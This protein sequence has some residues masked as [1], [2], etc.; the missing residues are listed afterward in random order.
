LGKKLSD[1]LS[2]DDVDGR[3][4]RVEE[5]L[6]DPKNFQYT[7][8]LQRVDSSID[9]V[10]DFLFNTRRGHCEYFASAAALLLRSMG[11]PTRVVNG[12]KG[13]EWNDLAGVYQIRQRM[14]HSWVEAYVN[15]YWRTVDPS[16]V[17]R[18]GD[19]GDEQLSLQERISRWAAEGTR[20]WL[21]YVIGYSETDQSR[22][23]GQPLMHLA[24]QILDDLADLISGRES[25]WGGDVSPASVAVALTAVV[26]LSLFLWRVRRSRSGARSFWRWR[27]RRAS[28]AERRFLPY[29]AWI[30]GLRKI[31][32]LRRPGQTPREF[33]LD[34]ARL[35]GSD[36][37]LRP[38][39]DLPLEVTDRLYEI[40]FG[41]REIDDSI[42]R[43]LAERVRAFRDLLPA[44]AEV[45]QQTRRG[46]ASKTLSLS[47]IP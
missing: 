42:Q 4:Q 44:L 13:A 33:A 26:M 23:I 36:E 31:D 34:V 39:S 17:Q 6:S 47:R 3:I 14:A 5:Y 11:T 27:R 16:P 2:P 19:A 9:P 22:L 25:L 35:M 43:P 40:R 15:G 38:W 28:S 21:A 7:L 8:D 45:H 41:G 12:F 46:A 30:K 1:G 20:I 29:E 32:W 10:E 18:D 24:G 37:R